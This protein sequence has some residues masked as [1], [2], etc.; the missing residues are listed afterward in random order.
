MHSTLSFCSLHLWLILL[1]FSASDYFEVNCRDH[2]L[3]VNISFC[4]SIRQGF[5]LFSSYNITIT[6]EKN[7]TNPLFHQMSSKCSY[8]PGHTKNGLKK[9][10]EMESSQGPYES[11]SPLS[12]SHLS[13]VFV[14]DNVFFFLS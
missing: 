7:P 8:F 12:F 2:I 10:F 5:P 1:C 4:I 6:R 9:N 13:D 14:K 3:S 11:S